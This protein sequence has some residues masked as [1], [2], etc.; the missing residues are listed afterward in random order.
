MSHEKLA[1]KANLDANNIGRIERGERAPTSITLFKLIYALDIYP[2]SEFL[3]EVV[4]VLHDE[5]S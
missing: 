2:Q 5:E 4:E 3:A 1:E